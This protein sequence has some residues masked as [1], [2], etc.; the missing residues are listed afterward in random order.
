MGETIGVFAKR[1]NV[2]V[3]TL[4]Y[5]EEIG[6]LMPVET[7]E[8]GHKLYGSKEESVLQRIQAWKFLGVPLEDIKRLLDESANDLST[9]LSLQKKLLLEQK[10]LIEGMIDAVEDAEVILKLSEGKAKEYMEVLYMVL[11][12]YRLEKEQRKFLLHHFSEEWVNQLYQPEGIDRNELIKLNTSY[13]FQLLEFMKNKVD[14]TSQQVQNVI[15]E[16]LQK[17][18]SLIDPVV[19]GEIAKQIELFEANE[20]LFYTVMPEPFKLFTEKAVE[21]Y[22]ANSEDERGG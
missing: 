5:Y 11:N 20:H 10:Q 18:N 9:T 13:L 16:M 4:R 14:P 6:L 17:V 1:M 21:Y 2:T 19:V 7:N 22:Y 3:R 12:T 8:Q 15:E